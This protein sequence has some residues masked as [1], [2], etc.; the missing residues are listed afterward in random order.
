MI[1]SSSLDEDKSKEITD[2]IVAIHI[3]DNNLG[4]LDKTGDEFM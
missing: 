2:N 1:C 3:I 4:Y